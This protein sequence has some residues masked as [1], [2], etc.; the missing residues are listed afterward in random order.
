MADGQL[1]FCQVGRGGAL[2]LLEVIMPL[3]EVV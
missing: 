2:C 1:R 3:I